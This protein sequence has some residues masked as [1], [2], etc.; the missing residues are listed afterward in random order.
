MIK[1]SC[2]ILFLGKKENEF[3]Q[4]AAV[5]LQENCAY[6]TVFVADRNEVLPDY[7][8]QWEGDYIIS[9]I[10]SWILPAELLAKAKI[11]AIN[12]HP[13]SPEYPGTGCTNFAIYNN[14]STYG[15]TCHHM[16]T[17][18]DTG[19]I[20]RV[21]RFE[22]DKDETV[23]SITQK[24]YTH[25]LQQFIEIFK[26]IANGETLPIA[27]ETWKRKAYTRKDLNALCEIKIDMPEEEIERRIKASTYQ[28]AWAFIKV[29]KRVFTL[30]S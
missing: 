7:V 2:R 4:Q 28:K 8:L 13:G 16:Q 24:C 30:Q 26:V 15:V 29:G 21:T 22:V 3:T 18:V 10:S 5:Y 12:F 25:L 27:D 20:I 11:A 23:F 9:F 14:E 19:N 1:S 17:S 6:S